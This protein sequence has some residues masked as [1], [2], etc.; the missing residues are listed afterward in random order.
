MTKV[1]VYRVEFYDVQ[2]DAMQRSR[3]WFTRDGAKRLNALV[4]ESSAEEIDDTDLEPGEEWTRRDFDPNRTVG[5]QRQV[6]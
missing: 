6:R 3:R 5:F 1:I 2:N 4:V